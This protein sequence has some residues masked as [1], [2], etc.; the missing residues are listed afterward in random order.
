MDVDPPRGELRNDISAAGDLRDR[1]R[2]AASAGAAATPSASW[3][4]RAR[5]ALD[6]LRAVAAFLHHHADTDVA[7]AITRELGVDA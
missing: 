4:E 5:Q 1:L 3:G 7:R 2:A 6:A